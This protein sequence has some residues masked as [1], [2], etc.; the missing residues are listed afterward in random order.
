MKIRPLADRVLVEWLEAETKTAGGIVL[1]DSAKVNGT[2][3][4]LHRNRD[5]ERWQRIPDYE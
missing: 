3:Y 5:K 1:L 2:F 4:K